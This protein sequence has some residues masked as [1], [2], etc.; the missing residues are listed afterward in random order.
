MS[1]YRKSLHYTV[2]VVSALVIG[3][4]AVTPVPT[5]PEE[6]QQRMEADRKVL[7]SPE[8]PQD[9]PITLYQAQALALKYNLDR[10]LKLMEEA[11][12]ARLNDVAGYAMLPQLTTSA[13]LLTR[14][15]DSFSTSYTPNS[16]T[17][18]DPAVSVDRSRATM[19]LGMVWNVL[20]FGVS[21]IRARQQSNLVLVAAERRRK[22]VQ[23]IMN[24]VRSAYWRAL[25]AQILS[26]QLEPLTARAQNALTIIQ[27]D[28]SIAWSSP[29][30]RLTY[31][32]TLLEIL[33]HLQALKR[34]AEAA[35][36]DFATLLNV[37][38][39]QKLYLAKP[40]GYDSRPVLQQVNV[41]ELERQALLNRPELREEDYQKRISADETHKAM[42]RMLP[43]LEFGASLNRDTNGFISPNSWAEAS[44][45][46]T[47]NLM[48][49]VAGP[50]TIDAAEAQQNYGEV[51]RLSVSMA[52]IAQVNVAARR[53]ALSRA[54]YDLA[55]GL[56]KVE[57]E[58]LNRCNC[59]NKGTPLD[60]VEYLRRATIQLSSRYRGDAAFVEVQNAAGAIA[61]SIGR[62]P[63]PEDVSVDQIEA[64]SQVLEKAAGEWTVV[65]PP[66]FMSPRE[67]AA[68]LKQDAV[69]VAAPTVA[70]VDPLEALSKDPAIGRFVT[71]TR[72]VGQGYATSAEFA[73]RRYPNLGALLPYAEMPPASAIFLAP[74]DEADIIAKLKAAGSSA[75]ERARILDGILPAK[76]AARTLSAD[77]AQA[78]LTAASARI[79]Q[80]LQVGLVTAD[81]ADRET[82]AI[83]AAASSSDEPKKARSRRRG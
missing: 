63:V 29:D 49:M 55:E 14:S 18:T 72:L 5:T 16:D 51:R 27:T 56:A 33:Q 53:F 41:D 25:N 22:V 76:V 78:A 7:F 50:S 10:R 67:G 43:G 74:P 75:K 79:R 65:K 58:Q 62:D 12:T 60:E 42:L 59:G 40:I 6:R 35:K 32:R 30:Q 71:F 45:K 28:Q 47:W 2:A 19:N 69:G 46:L 70:D 21:Y 4:C 54:D 1:Q 34:D 11:A 26:S 23:T 44:L 66:L 80:L 61:V 37:D 24:D 39:G 13:G 82:Q 81:E 38:Y 83:A 68:G 64:L 73:A 57:D 20:D 77:H 15:S 8:V 31:N 3:G 52:V 9:R 36:I 48:N 17:L